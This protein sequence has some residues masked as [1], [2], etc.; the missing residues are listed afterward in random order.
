M[1][2]NRNIVMTTCGSAEEADAIASA[3]V[4][5]HLAACVQA[6]P[7]SSTFFWE[8]EVQ[9]EA[10]VILFVKTTSDRTDA[11][12]EVIKELHSY[13]LPEVVVVPITG[14]SEE[15]LAWIKD[16]TT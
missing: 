16:V 13:D 9:Q 6:M 11:A 1:T 8:G 2:T 5:Q 10:E 12:A 3:L 14:G 4:G 7:I 15:Y